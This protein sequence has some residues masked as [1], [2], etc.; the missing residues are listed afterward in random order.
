MPI[1]AFRLPDDLAA[2]LE[3]ELGSSAFTPR[4]IEVS[5]ADQYI[6]NTALELLASA[7][8]VLGESWSDRCLAVLLLENQLLK[9]PSHDLT[10]FDV[11]LNALGLKP[12]IGHDIPMNAF[13]LKEGFSTRDFRGFTSE[14]IRKL[15]R[16]DR[17]HASIQRPDC[18]RV[19]WQY[20]IRA[21]RDVSK[22]TL[23]RYT[24]GV[25]DVLAEIQR[26]LIVTE[27]VEDTLS[28]LGN[29]SS[30]HCS[31]ESLSLPPFEMEILR[32]LCADRKIYWVSDRCSSELN[33]LV[34]YPL[35]SAVVVIKPPGSDL[36]IEIKRAGTRGP[37]LLDVIAHR[38]G[39][40]A[41]ISHRL[42]GG[43][44]GWLAQRE[45]AAADLFS[46]IFRLVHGKEG[47]C[48][49]GIMNSSVVTIPAATGETHILDY[50]TDEQQFG[51]GFATTRA[52]MR[53]CAESF[54]S[55][56]GVVRPSYKGEAGATLKF[57]AQAIPQQAVIVGSSSFR[58]DRIALYLSEDGPGQYFRVGLG[59][60]YSL[61]DVRWLADSVLEEILGEFS[62]PA[63]EYL[64]YSQYIRDAFQVPENRNRADLNYLSV[65][66]QIGECWGTLLAFRG[67]SDGESFVQRN[68]GLKSIWKDGR[69]EVR[70]IFMDHDDLTVAGG[71]YSYLWPWRETSGMQRDQVHILGGPM[72][73]E[74]IPGEVGA[75]KTIYRVS[76]DVGDAGLRSLK[77]TLR[78]AYQK[79]QAELTTNQELRKLFYP[80]F[81]DGYRDFDELVP[82]FLERD[83]S[84]IDSWEAEADDY[85]RNKGYESELI[86][87]YTKTVSHFRE[88]F[89]QMSFLYSK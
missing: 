25:E 60:G 68:V 16:L 10:E 77:D 81:L 61:R 20:F 40:D 3:A 42:F 59:R 28:R 63:V 35:T 6:R 89:E 21:A 67:F 52:A 48:S 86:A 76:S 62:V 53:A 34:E 11:I 46:K 17:V 14:L 44:L 69:W 64:D 29:P 37:R 9:L 22:L 15:S 43:S 78:T 13:V 18:D 88:F 32:R 82:G 70:I 38:N 45:T 79:A 75:L 50:F 74:I 51:T 7:Q 39:V 31:R 23:V 30:N 66:E 54:P 4:L 19:A 84:Q 83:P 87:E 55:D 1:E 85:L 12:Q 56:T 58:L 57:I 65:M 5:R 80:R 72:G 24:F 47:P 2:L 73:D 8:G 41:P 27:G 36:E 26:G 71:R 49:K 33:S